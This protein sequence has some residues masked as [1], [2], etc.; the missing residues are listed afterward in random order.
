MKKI[1]IFG[2]SIM[3][4]VMHFYFQKNSEYEVAGFTVDATYN[5]C[6]I[7]CGLEVLDFESI[8]KTH[9][10]ACYDLFIAIGP[11]KMNKI[12]EQKFLDAKTKGYRLVSYISPSAICDSD[13]GENSFIADRVVINPFCKIG[14]N[15]YIFEGCVVSND[16]VIGDNCYISPNVSI[17]TFCHIQENSI[18]GSGAVI[19]TSV[20]IAK[21]SLIGAAVYMS[22]NTNENGVYGRKSADYLGPISEKLDISFD[23]GG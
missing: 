18:I 4:K 12:R 13:I 17:G 23:I 22:K 1:I 10:P 14:D 9:P 8:E 16:V 2:N 19:K 3:A 7:M 5:T 6:D 21:K 20:A 11:S 15:S